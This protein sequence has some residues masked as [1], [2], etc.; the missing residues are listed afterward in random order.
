VVLAKSLPLCPQKRD[1]VPILEEAGWT[2]EPL[3]TGAENLAPSELRT[4]NLPAP[5]ESLYRLL[6]FALQRCDILV[7]H[8]KG[9]DIQSHFNIPSMHNTVDVKI[10]KQRLPV[11]TSISGSSSHFSP[12]SCLRFYEYLPIQPLPL[13]NLLT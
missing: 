6:H 8:V 10:Y 12:D 2:S 13:Q 3:W 5:S 7:E 4:K 11:S 9:E 1:H